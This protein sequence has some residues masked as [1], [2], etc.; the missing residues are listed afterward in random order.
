MIGHLSSTGPGS[1][2]QCPVSCERVVH[3]AGCLRAGCP[4]LATEHVGGREWMGCRA[5]IFAPLIDVERFESRQRT[6]AGFGGLR[7]ARVPLPVCQIEVERTFA[8]REGAA[9]VNPDFLVAD[10]P[11]GYRV[12]V[13]EGADPR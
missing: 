8:H 4:H 1:C 13:R 12:I 2:R 10:A 9:C 7:I 5:G 11:R 3:P 6:L